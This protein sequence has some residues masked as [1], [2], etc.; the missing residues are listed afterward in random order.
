MGLA[1]LAVLLS[2]VMG[3]IAIGRA[4][5]RR[6]DFEHFY[7]D[8]RYVLHHGRLN[9]QDHLPD[10]RGGPHLPWYLPP[11]T[12]AFVPIVAAGEWIGRRVGVGDAWIAGTIWYALSIAA[13]WLAV[14][15]VGRFW[16]TGTGGIARGLSRQLLPVLLC[17][18]ALYEAVRFNQLSLVCLGLIVGGLTLTL[19]RSRWGAGG[20]LIGLAAAIKLIPVVLLGWL[21]L[22]RRWRAVA[23]A[24]VTIVAVDVGLSLAVFGVDTTIEYHDR[25]VR[26]SLSGASGIS[27]IN[28][29]Q[30]AWIRDRYGHFLDHRNQGLAVVLG[31]LLGPIGPDRGSPDTRVMDL[32]AT[33]VGWVYLAITVASIGGLLWASRAPARAMM[34][35]TG[36]LEASLWMLAMMWL[37]PLMRQYY[38]IWCYPAVATLA[39]RFDADLRAGRPTGWCLLGLGAWVG[40]MLAWMAPTLRAAGANLWMLALMAV[41]LIGAGR[42]AAD[43]R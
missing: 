17:T 43:S 30:H 12:L 32:P 37:S 20:V 38:L 21:V 9:T 1:A 23:T 26:R 5:A 13:F 33:I 29:Q 14:W 42:A 36:A 18:P 3:A 8:A 7:Y 16:T 27:L 39:G 25:W 11:T 24:A 19:R 34:P 4:G 28:E 2:V 6:W 15:C 40:G 41:A 10:D 22:K 31:R 35:D